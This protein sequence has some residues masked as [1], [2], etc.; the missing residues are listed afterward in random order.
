[1]KLH[2]LVVPSLIVLLSASAGVVPPALAEGPARPVGYYVDAALTKY[3]SLE[4][5]RQKIEMRRSETARAGA[6]DDPKLWF[7]LS[8]VPTN[9]WSFSR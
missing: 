4:S 6:L 5:M 2:R 8:N 7:S 9:S 3:P 1:M